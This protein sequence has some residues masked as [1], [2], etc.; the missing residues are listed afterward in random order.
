[1]IET[2]FTWALVVAYFGWWFIIVPMILIG[3]AMMSH[4]FAKKL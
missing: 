3:L 1:V 2:I 4:S